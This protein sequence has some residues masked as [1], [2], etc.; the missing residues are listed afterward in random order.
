MHYNYDNNLIGSL[1]LINNAVNYKVNEHVLKH[2]EA[3]NEVLNAEASHKYF[4]CMFGIEEERIVS[5]ETGLRKTLEWILS[6]HYDPETAEETTAFRP[7]NFHS[8][9]IAEKLP[10]SWAEDAR[11]SADGDIRITSKAQIHSDT[12]NAEDNKK[13]T[14]FVSDE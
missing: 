8:V 12:D 7:V 3:R 10:K 5:L 13:G 11:S 1:H 9:E 4:N 6:N 14:L 2:L